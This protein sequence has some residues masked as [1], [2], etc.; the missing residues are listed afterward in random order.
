MMG[1]MASLELAE[2]E[3]EQLFFFAMS[4]LRDLEKASGKYDSSAK[5]WNISHTNK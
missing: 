1:V 3:L 5:L 2:E 4:A